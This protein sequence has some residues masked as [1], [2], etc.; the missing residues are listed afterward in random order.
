GVAGARVEAGAT[1]IIEQ[2]L[3]PG[4]RH[5]DGLMPAIESI[6][7]RLAVRPDGLDRICISIGPGGYTALRIAATTANLLSETT[8]AKIAAVPSAAVVASN[9]SGNRPFAVCLASKRGTTHATLFDGSNGLGR[10]VGLIG[11]GDV[12]SLGVDLI[13]AD[14]F[15]PAAIRERAVEIGIR[16]NPPVFSPGACL[17]LGLEMEPTGT[18]LPVYAREAEAV[19]LWRSRDRG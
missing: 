11:P 18:A 8:G 12:G 2:H 19:R 15:L 14:R 13:I 6:R 1:Q 4:G 9:I 7:E 10:A 5:D 16:I 3:E 17:R